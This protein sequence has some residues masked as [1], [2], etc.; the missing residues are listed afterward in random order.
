MESVTC[1]AHDHPAAEHLSAT[2]R[3]TCRSVHVRV[4]QAIKVTLHKRLKPSAI[5]LNELGKKAVAPGHAHRVALVPDCK[6][7]AQ[8]VL[9]SVECP[10]ATFTCAELRGEV[11]VH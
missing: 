10:H 8:H 5:T 2:V 1:F 6:R 3:V 9:P 11:G 7:A 4:V